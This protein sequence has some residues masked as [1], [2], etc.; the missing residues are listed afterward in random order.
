MIKLIVTTIDKP[1]A[2]HFC[3]RKEDHFFDRKAFEIKPAKIQKIAVAFANADGGEFV[4]GISDNKE[5]SNPEDRW[6]GMPEFEDFNQ[7]I[8]TLQEITPSLP[9]RFNFLACNGLPGYV[10]HIEVDKSSMVHQASDKKIYIRMSAQSLPLNDTEKILSLT[11]AK[12]ATSFEDQVVN[13]AE[14]ESLVD[15]NQIQMFLADYSPKSDPLEFIVNQH[16]VDVGTWEPKVSGIL[17]FANEPSAIIPRQCAIKIA[18]YE[19]KEDDPERDHLKETLAI[20]GPLYDQ[21]HSAAEAITDIMSSISIWTVNGLSKVKYPPEAIWEILVNAAIHR[22]Y[23][24]SDNIHIHIYNNRVEII[25][26]GK[27]PGYVTSE[28]ILDVRYSRNPRI[29]RTLSRY[30]NPPNQ[31]M[32]EGLNTAFQ[33]M[34][35]WRLESPKIF[36]EGNYVKAIIPHTLLATPEEAVLSFLENNETIKNSQARDL[37]GI[38]SEN[39][40]KTVFYKLRDNNLIERVPGLDGPLAA[41]RKKI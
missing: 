14:I 20:E 4:I 23:S 19:T 40:M 18:R 16:L 39:T 8:Q 15:G 32:G 10:L 33:K 21:L 41:W 12:G 9:F 28:N 1:D 17:L 2:L 6:N 27:F 37:T 31:D 3:D 25:S 34:K 36:E 22:D 35:E 13:G 24:I 5:H 30:K 26:P 29:V 7:H 38:K 11:Y